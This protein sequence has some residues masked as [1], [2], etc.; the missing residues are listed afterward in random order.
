[1]PMQC[2]FVCLS[3]WGFG[4]LLLCRAFQKCRG[5][6]FYDLAWLGCTFF[7]NSHL[8]VTMGHR[9]LSHIMY[10]DRVVSDLYT[11]CLKLL[12]WL[13]IRSLKSSSAPANILCCCVVLAECGLV[14]YNGATAFTRDRAFGFFPA[15]SRG[16]FFS[17]LA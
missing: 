13:L 4:Y 6:K 9:L 8:M 12:L 14:D 10:F 16:W 7:R 3:F 5:R 2:L 1:M 11:S 15:V 17:L